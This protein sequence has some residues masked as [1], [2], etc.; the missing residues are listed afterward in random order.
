MTATDTQGKSRA[1][2]LVLVL[3]CLAEF[4]IALDFAIMNVMLPSLREDVAFSQ[5]QL[6]WVVSAY[7]V[8]FGGF[9]LL[10][11]RAADLFGRKRV[12]LTGIVGFTAVSAVSGTLDAPWQLIAARAANGTHPWTRHSVVPTGKP[13][14]N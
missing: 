12:L 2:T 7:A 3:L 6:Q 4:M 13:R 10:G 5:S 9:L 8:T 1:G 11:G 14:P